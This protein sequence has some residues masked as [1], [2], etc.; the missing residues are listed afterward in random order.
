M[1]KAIEVVG[2]IPEG[3]NVIEITTPSQ[4]IGKTYEFYTGDPAMAILDYE[5]RFKKQV[6]EII[7]LFNY[8]AIEATETR[9]PA[10]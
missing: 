7:R 9:C 3:I 1:A 10:Q 6:K 2:K 8:T 5:K 4:L